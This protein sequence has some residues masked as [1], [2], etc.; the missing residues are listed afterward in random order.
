MCSPISHETETRMRR[1]ACRLLCWS[2]L[3]VA[4]CAAAP[5]VA[6]APPPPIDAA[7]PAKTETA[8]FAL[9]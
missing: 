5:A 4:G 1:F 9:G 6:T 3:W 7:V 8:T 2:M